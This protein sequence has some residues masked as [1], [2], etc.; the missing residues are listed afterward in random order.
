[1]GVADD[2]GGLPMKVPFGGDETGVG[3]RLPVPWPP[4]PP[5]PGVGV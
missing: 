3:G 4:L 1:M 2:G 5:P